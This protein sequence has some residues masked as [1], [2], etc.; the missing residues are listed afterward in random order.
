[1]KKYLNVLLVLGLV[2]LPVTGI[3]LSGCVATDGEQGLQTLEQMSEIDYRRLKLYSTLGV[4]IAAHRLVAEG[5][6]SAEDLV[7][8]ADLLSSIKSTPIL[9]GAEFLI[10]E[11]L[12][13]GGL[14][15]VEVEALVQIVVFELQARGVFDL[16]ALDGTI[17]LAP[18]TEDFIDSLI[19]AVRSAGVVSAGELEEARSVGITE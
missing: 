15:S 2:A 8:A 7:T 14:D 19:A 10:E 1:M 4:K 13:S 3:A 5:T 18:R 11:L 17:V 9:G 16:L 12:A 6:V